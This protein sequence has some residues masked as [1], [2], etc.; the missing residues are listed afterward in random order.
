MFRTRAQRLLL[1]AA[2]VLACPVSAGAEI[3]N[4]IPRRDTAVVAPQP[5]SAVGK[6]TNET[7]SSCSAVAIARDKVVTAAHCLFNARTGQF[8]GADALHF[9]AGYRGGKYAAH[10][11]VTIYQIGTGFDP[12]RHAETSDH[13][14]AV[15]TL[16]QPLPA[17]VVPFKLGE[18]ATSRG[19][20]AM[21]AG[22]PQDR[23]HALAFDN[24]CEL[25]ERVGG[26]RLVL[27]TC[28][29]AAGTSGAPIL[30]RA[31]GEMR[32]AGI[33]IAQVTLGGAQR[34]LAVP[35]YAIMR[36]DLR[37]IRP[38]AKRGVDVANS[39]GCRS[40]ERVVLAVLVDRPAPRRGDEPPGGMLLTAIA[41]L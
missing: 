10:A 17:G 19:T 36:A 28:K 38:A 5:W 41:V 7:G 29:G 13:D 27:H 4:S 14:W 30:M 25:Q 31:G 37:A 33:Q 26:G 6:L 23:A 8:I 3:T 9:L 24:D 32:I 40:P 1:L 12:L 11:R 21:M 34:M 35:A 39:A 16:A 22:Y 2:W 15:L 18:Q 20:R